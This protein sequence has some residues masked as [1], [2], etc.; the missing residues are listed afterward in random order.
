M[1]QPET[2]PFTYLPLDRTEFS[3]APV[4]GAS[5]APPFTPTPRQS[6]LPPRNAYP[7]G[8]AAPV[9]TP[10]GAPTFYWE[11]PAPSST[12]LGANPYSDGPTVPPPH[13]PP[14]L[15]AP[16][17]MSPA[18]GA[19]PFPSTSTAPLAPWAFIHTLPRYMAPHT[20]T[21]T[22]VT[23]NGLCRYYVYGTQEGETVVAFS[24][25]VQG[26]QDLYT[27]FGI[28]VPNA[29]GAWVPNNQSDVP[30]YP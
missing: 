3:H 19:Q 8:L 14:N 23:P 1:P 27:Q 16:L 5:G 6:D 30:H 18:P 11:S 17:L 26:L 7:W 20:R 24:G 22:Y 29:S 2:S 25:P 13:Q 12:P 15:G 21:P 4:S 9:P 28:Q 10:L